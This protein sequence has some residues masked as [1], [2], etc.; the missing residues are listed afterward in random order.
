MNEIEKEIRAH[1]KSKHVIWAMWNVG[2]GKTHIPYL[3]LYE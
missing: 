3:F 1:H 2:R